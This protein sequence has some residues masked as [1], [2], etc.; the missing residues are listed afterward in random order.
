MTIDSKTRIKISN[1]RTHEFGLYFMDYLVIPVGLEK[2]MELVMTDP[3]E[4][5]NI[6]KDILSSARTRLHLNP[7]VIIS[8]ACLYLAVCCY[9][10]ETKLCKSIINTIVDSYDISI[11]RSKD[12]ADIKDIL[13]EIIRIMIDKHSDTFEAMARKC[14]KEP[15]I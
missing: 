5:G 3:V 6:I 15:S 4:T 7:G 11:E 1:K 13:K 9:I 2:I 14:N 8:R 12:P 10:D